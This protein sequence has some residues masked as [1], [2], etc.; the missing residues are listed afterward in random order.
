MTHLLDFFNERANLVKQNI[1]AVN[2]IPIINYGF[3]VSN[4]KLDDSNTIAIDNLDDLLEATKLYFENS[5][6]DYKERIFVNEFI[7][8][9]KQMYVHLMLDPTITYN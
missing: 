8:R 1:F 3:L 2:T 6:I 5:Q 4:V 9:D 7:Q